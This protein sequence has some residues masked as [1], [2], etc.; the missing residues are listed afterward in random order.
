MDFLA[1]FIE[2]TCYC[3][4]ISPACKFALDGFVRNLK[5]KAYRYA[6]K[7]C[8]KIQIHVNARKK[9]RRDS[10]PRMREHIGIAADAVDNDFIANLAPNILAETPK[11]R[12]PANLITGVWVGDTTTT[13]FGGIPDKT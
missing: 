1:H 10:S 11:K 12:Q 13:I 5:L 6:P 2:I 8:R 4:V 9:L 3:S 7:S